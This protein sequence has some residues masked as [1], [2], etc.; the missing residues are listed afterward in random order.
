MKRSRVAE[1]EY[2][3]LG[4][5]SARSARPRPEA[6]VLDSLGWDA[7]LRAAYEQHDRPDRGPA[8]VSRV[9]R[10]VCTLLGAD[11][12]RR[13]SVAGRM[14]AAAARDLSHLPC[15]GD[16]VVVQT[17]PD[18]RWTVEAVLPRRGTVWCAA[19]P[20][21]S[22]SNVDMVMEVNHRVDAETGLVDA[23]RALLAPGR[24]LGL[25]GADVKGRA[26]L[27]AALAG[28]TVLLP[29]GGAL[30]PLPGGGAVIHAPGDRF[31][32]DLGDT[33]STSALRPSLKSTTSANGR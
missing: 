30:V 28:A 25:I 17:W 3:R 18:L 12:V 21:P 5:S 26:H 27:V 9:D 16:W 13:A 15:P 31:A 20:G 22:A 29:A 2:P 33:G 8:R 6:A 11:A 32:I 10:G 19:R 23:L 1:L 24:T 7:R 4:A 14:L